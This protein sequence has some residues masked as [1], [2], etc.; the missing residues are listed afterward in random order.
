MLPRKIKKGARPANNYNAPPK[1]SPRDSNHTT[2]RTKK[3]RFL[4]HDT[5]SV[6]VAQVKQ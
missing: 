4:S 6:L 2:Q 5:E 3:S 1:Q